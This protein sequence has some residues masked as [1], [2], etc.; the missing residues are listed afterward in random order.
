MKDF[1]KDCLLFQNNDREMRIIGALA[2]FWV[3]CV[4][5]LIYWFF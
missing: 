4:V 1:I 3:A 2:W 5:Y